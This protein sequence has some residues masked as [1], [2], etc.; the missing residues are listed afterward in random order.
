MT[1]ITQVSAYQP[2]LQQLSR[3]IEINIQLRRD[4]AAAEIQFKQKLSELEQQVGEAQAGLAKSKTK[5][6]Y[7]DALLT[8]LSQ[9]QTAY[10]RSSE[11]FRA[12]TLQN[13]TLAS[14]YTQLQVESK[15]NQERLKRGKEEAQ[16]LQKKLHAEQAETQ[17]LQQQLV[18][19]KESSAQA[20]HAC[21]LTNERQ[22]QEVAQLTALLMS[23]EK[24]LQHSSITGTSERPAN[25]R[26]NLKADLQLLKKSPLFDANWYLQ[27]YP[28]VAKAGMN[29]AE[30]YLRHGGFENRNP[31]AQFDSGA[32][33]QRYPDVRQS[34]ANPLIHFLLDGERQGCEAMVVKESDGG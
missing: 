23:A 14:D 17:K 33:L 22:A 25:G 21:Q 5:A 11:A 24:R 4:L 9:L 12:L 16:Q 8:E 6:A 13:E 20:L 19:L 28:D 27:T 18:A 29:P 34:G 30:H 7:T 10:A 1:T 2:L 15:Q 26:N 32:Y 31:S 3:Q